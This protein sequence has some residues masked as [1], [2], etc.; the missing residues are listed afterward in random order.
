MRPRPEQRLAAN[1]LLQ[2][3]TTIFALLSGGVIS[4][5]IARTLGPSE[6]GSYALAL[7]IVSTVKTLAGF[8]LARTALAFAAASGR[9]DGRRARSGGCCRALGRGRLRR[10]RAG[11]GCRRPL[12]T[13]FRDPRLAVLLPVGAGSSSPAL[14]GRVLESALEGRR[15][16]ICWPAQPIC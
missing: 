15:A 1:A 6:M 3:A 2:F 11:A 10:G 13:F 5:V 9:A 16:S 14:I 8:G 7:I 4:I 12:A